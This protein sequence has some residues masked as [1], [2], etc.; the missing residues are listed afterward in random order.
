MSPFAEVLLE[1]HDNALNFFNTD[2]H[3]FGK[4]YIN[5]YTYILYKE[6]EKL[7][8]FFYFH[9]TFSLSLIFSINKISKAINATTS[10]K[11]VT[12]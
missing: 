10:E 9:N 2:Y 11:N 8:L 3:T 4:K 12:L 5:I 7:L 1:I 6:K